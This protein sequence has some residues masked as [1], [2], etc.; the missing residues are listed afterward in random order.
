MATLNK[1][2]DQPLGLNEVQAFFGRRYSHNNGFALE[3]LGR[4]N[5]TEPFSWP[6]NNSGVLLEPTWTFAPTGVNTAI[7]TDAASLITTDRELDLSSVRIDADVTI[8]SVPPGNTAPR[9]FLIVKDADGNITNSG[10]QQARYTEASTINSPGDYTLSSSGLNPQGTTTVPA[11]SNLAFVFSLQS[12]LDRPTE[13]TIHNVRV[14][15]DSNELAIQGAYPPRGGFAVENLG[16]ITFSD[17]GSQTAW[18]TGTP[19]TTAGDFG[20][21]YTPPTG[22]GIATGN[23]DASI[24]AAGGVLRNTSGGNLQLASEDSIELDV[25]FSGIPTGGL[26]ISS[27][28]YDFQGSGGTNRRLWGDPS[29]RIDGNGPIT[30][31]FGGFPPV[32]GTGYTWPNGRDLYLAFYD[33][34]TSSEVPFSFTVDAVRISE[35][36]DAYQRQ[37]EE[38]LSYYNR[39]GSIV[40][41]SRDVTVPGSEF[42]A[43][44]DISGLGGLSYAADIDSTAI[45][46]LNAV[47]GTF[48]NDIANAGIAL[49]NQF[50]NLGLTA[51]AAYAGNTPTSADFSK[52]RRRSN[53]GDGNLGAGRWDIRDGATVTSNSVAYSNWAGWEG[54]WLVFDLSAAETTEVNS[55]IALT[56]RHNQR[57][58]IRFRNGTGS[59]SAL[60]NISN[61]FR[62]DDLVIVPGTDDA[63]FFQL[64]P[65]LNP[66]GTPPNGAV[67]GADGNRRIEVDFSFD[68]V[69]TTS[70]VT[71]NSGQNITLTPAFA[72]GSTNRAGRISTSGGGEGVTTT[73]IN[74]GISAIP[75]QVTL[76]SLRG[77][78]DG[79][80]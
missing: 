42:S 29:R 8:H 75:G 30:L 47:T 10:L 16:T 22:T 27:A 18:P 69:V 59:T 38:H 9:I 44:F 12:S 45:V 2:A 11:N 15:F 3:N 24:T 62:V 26:L 28:L 36:G 25:T 14:S 73:A 71:V 70:E 31:P 17:T 32:N 57:V 51:T 64:G 80:D 74:G 58:S 19:T 67:T 6:G 4:I 77:V 78:D 20:L 1:A 60:S 79:E 35:T 53:D 56:S 39:D 34:P 41:S 76:A 55:L 43:T 7:Q 13:Y 72:T 66:I 46:P 65:G 21:T 68:T 40:P 49:R 52:S 5:A 23:N 54:T 63:A 50:T 61:E 48:S 37:L 33:T